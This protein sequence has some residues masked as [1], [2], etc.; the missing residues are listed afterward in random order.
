MLGGVG[1]GEA[2]PP[3]IV[4][5]VAGALGVLAVELAAEVCRHVRGEKLLRNLVEGDAPTTSAKR[6]HATPIAVP[7]IAF[8][9]GVLGVSVRDAGTRHSRGSRTSEDKIP[10]TEELVL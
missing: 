3:Q 6:K 10:A 7:W 9:P 4:G 2:V 8:I 1:E 5:L